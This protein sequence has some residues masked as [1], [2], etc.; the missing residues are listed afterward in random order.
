MAGYYITARFIS[1]L[2]LQ[3]LVF[4]T[5]IEKL[6]AAFWRKIHLQIECTHYYYDLSL[7]LG[8]PADH[9]HKRGGVFNPRVDFLLNVP[10]SHN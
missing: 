6:S 9:N 3:Y 1:A 5:S 4:H 8:Y 10:P 2:L 7:S